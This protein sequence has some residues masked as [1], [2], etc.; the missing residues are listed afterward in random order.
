MELLVDNCKIVL[1]DFFEDKKSPEKTTFY[2]G[3]HLD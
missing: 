1:L 2:E 3:E